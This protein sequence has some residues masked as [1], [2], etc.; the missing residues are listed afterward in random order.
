M[1]HCMTLFLNGFLNLNSAHLLKGF[2]ILNPC[3]GIILCKG[4]PKELVHSIC[5]ELMYSSNKQFNS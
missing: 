5:S 1:K 3:V 4:I 2:T